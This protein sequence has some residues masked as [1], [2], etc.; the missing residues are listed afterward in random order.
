MT[1]SN[2]TETKAED[3]LFE[4]IQNQ[5]NDI[6][7][8]REKLRDLNI[9]VDELRKKIKNNRDVLRDFREKYAES[10]TKNKK[11]CYVCPKFELSEIAE[12]E[13]CKSPSPVLQPSQPIAIPTEIK[14][15]K[16]RKNAKPKPKEI[17]EIN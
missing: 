11:K 3:M 2:I 13:R 7:L 10:C 16:T 4:S 8:K 17:I 9:Q 14:I 1:E 12:I 15:K 6:V 5:I